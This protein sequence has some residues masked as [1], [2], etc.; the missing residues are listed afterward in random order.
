MSEHRRDGV[1][2]FTERYEA[3]ALARARAVEWDV[4]DPHAVI[5]VTFDDV[6]AFHYDDGRAPFALPG[7]VEGEQ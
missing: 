1:E 3:G 2:G 5:R 7:L 6:P 4:P